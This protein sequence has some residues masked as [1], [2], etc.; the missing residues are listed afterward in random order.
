MLWEYRVEQFVAY[1]MPRNPFKGKQQ[2][3][4]SHHTPEELE[5]IN[6]LGAE[7]WELVNAVSQD[8]LGC[9][10]VRLYFKRAKV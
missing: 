10:S 4:M 9:I 3:G 1:G 5:Y 2:P 8:A 6:R 7:G